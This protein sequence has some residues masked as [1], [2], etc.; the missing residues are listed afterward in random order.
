MYQAFYFAGDLVALLAQGRELLGQTWHDD[1]CGLRAG[2]GHRLF[3][4]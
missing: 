4:A 3:A 2:H 1:C